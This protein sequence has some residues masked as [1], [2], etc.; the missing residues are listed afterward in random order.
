MIGRLTGVLLEKRPPQLLLDVRGVGY[1]IEAPMSTFYVLPELGESFTLHTHL[2]VREDAQLLF[3]FASEA[4]RGLFRALIKVN[5]VGAKVALAI[6]SG[7]SVDDFA[8]SVD[9]A[10][11]SA[12]TRVPGIGKKTAE[13]LVVEMRD[14]LDGLLL[15]SASGTGGS[16][17]TGGALGDATAHATEALIALGYKS[18]DAVKMVKSA[19]LEA[20]TTEQIIR[21]ALRSTHR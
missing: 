18:S 15:D 4:E 19:A 9:S 8:L 1:E 7:I 5:G 6:L 10:D 17:G 14:K 11:I 13:R 21:A 2:H 20:G 3:G 12:L 16:V